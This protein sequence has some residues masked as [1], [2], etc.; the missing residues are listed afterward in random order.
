[1]PIDV[2]SSINRSKMVSYRGLSFEQ[3]NR[4]SF[5]HQKNHTQRNMKTSAHHSFLIHCANCVRGSHIER[6]EVDCKSFPDSFPV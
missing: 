6:N 5:I 2:F 1:M 3:L 4:R